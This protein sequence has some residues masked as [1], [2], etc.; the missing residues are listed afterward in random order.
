VARRRDP[1][2]RRLASTV[3]CVVLLEHAAL[4]SCDIPAG[5]REGETRGLDKMMQEH[6]KIIF[7]TQGILGE[8]NV[9]V[10]DVWGDVTASPTVAGVWRTSQCVGAGRVD[11]RTTSSGSKSSSSWVTLEPAISPTSKSIAAR[12]IGSMGCRTVVSGGSVQFM[13]AESS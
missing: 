3:A 4:P 6:D 9:S 1:V 5:S 8:R 7:E 10:R 11:P 12:P 2:L 13:K